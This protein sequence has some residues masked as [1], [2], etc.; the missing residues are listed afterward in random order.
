[1]KNGDFEKIKIFLG[2]FYKGKPCYEVQ[3]TVFC[4]LLMKKVS[5]SYVSDFKLCQRTYSEKHYFYPLPLLP[6]FQKQSVLVLS[7]VFLHRYCMLLQYVCMC[8][9]A[10]TVINISS[11][12]NIMISSHICILYSNSSYTY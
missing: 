1:M 2:S 6:S 5:H 4:Y 9:C 8:I 3:L 12:M 10:C 7:S 11:L